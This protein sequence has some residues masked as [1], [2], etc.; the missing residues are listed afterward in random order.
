MR[1][2]AQRVARELGGL[3]VRINVR[4]PEVPAAQISIAMGAKAALTAIDE[5]VAAMR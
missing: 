5:R 1:L 3:L 2:Q 4:E